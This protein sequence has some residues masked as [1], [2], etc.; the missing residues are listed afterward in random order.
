M[1]CDTTFLNF[2]QGC[3]SYKDFACIIVHIVCMCRASRAAVMSE[4]DLKRTQ[5]L[6]ETNKLS[7]AEAKLHRSQ[8]EQAKLRKEQTKLRMR[9]Q[10]TEEKLEQGMICTCF[11]SMWV[12][13]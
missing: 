1:G 13:T 2:P 12:S 7:E 11:I 10:E 6:W 5:W 9:H 3:L 8:Q 4:L